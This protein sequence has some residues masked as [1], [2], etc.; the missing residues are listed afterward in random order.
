MAERYPCLA[1]KDW[2]KHQHYSKRRPPW[3]KLYTALLDDAQFL[4]LPE[5]AQLQLVKLWILAARMCHPLPYDARLLAGKIGCKSKLQLDALIASGFLVPCYQ[6][7]SIVLAKREQNA[8]P[9]ST[10]NREQRIESVLV[11]GE[12]APSGAGVPPP[13]S[14]S[15]VVPAAGALAPSDARPAELPP[16]SPYREPERGLRVHTGPE[17]FGDPDAILRIAGVKRP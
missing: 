15:V 17:R 6:D 8:T 13:Y 3:I 5:V 10:E 16:S 12:P 1:I 11:R 2:T 9:L 14:G 4:A 7:A